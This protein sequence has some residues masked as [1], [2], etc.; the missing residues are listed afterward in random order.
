MKVTMIP[1]DV[2]VEIPRLKGE[3]VVEVHEF[4]SFKRFLQQAIDHYEP[5]AKG[6]VNAL[7]YQKLTNVIDAA[8]VAKGEIWFEDADFLKLQEAVASAQWLSAKMNA[9]FLPF[10]EAIKAA[11]TEVLATEKK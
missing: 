6:H 11:R 7:L 5:F 2:Q 8:D 4:R 3:A 1:P 10:Y 9:A